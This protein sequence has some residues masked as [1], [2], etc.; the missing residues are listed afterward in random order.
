[1]N[2]KHVGGIEWQPIQPDARHTWLTEGLHAE[3]DTFIPMGTKEAKAEKAVPEDVI[4]KPI[5]VV[6]SY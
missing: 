4:F 2:V 3:F 6:S 5:V 1:M